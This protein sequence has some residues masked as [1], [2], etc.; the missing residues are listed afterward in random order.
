MQQVPSDWL[1]KHPDDIPLFRIS[2]L[3]FNK[4]EVMEFPLFTRKEDAITSYN[5]LQ[6]T[7][8]NQNN[9]INKSPEIGVSSVKDIISLWNTGGFEGR[10]LEIYPSMDSIDNARNIMGLPVN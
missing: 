8:K 5:R 7:K 3:A 9:I 4:D 1:E 2:N 10:A 6:E